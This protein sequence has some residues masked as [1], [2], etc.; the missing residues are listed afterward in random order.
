M[1]KA[2]AY[3]REIHLFHDAPGVRSALEITALTLK[4][5]QHFQAS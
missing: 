5:A 4:R 1:D 2:F 3:N